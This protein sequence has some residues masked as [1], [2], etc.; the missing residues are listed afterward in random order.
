MEATLT[1]KKEA[2]NTRRINRMPLNLP[3][4]AEGRDTADSQWEEITRLRDVSSF[5]AAFTLSRPVK[6]GRLI[7]L[8]LPMP[9]Q[10]RCYD[11]FEAQYHVWGVV[12]RCVAEENAEDE[13]YVLGVAFIGKVPPKSFLEDPSRLFDVSHKSEDEHGLWEVKPLESEQEET[14][15][16]SED[17]RHSRYDIPVNLTV[18]LLDA[19]GKVT[20]T[21][22]TVTENISLSGASIFTSL[23]VENGR[24]LKVTSVQDGAVIKAIVRGKRIGQDGIPRLH[25]EFI[26]QMFPLSGIID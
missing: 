15:L 14:Q 4:K 18:E 3:L 21:E 13:T 11:F 10:M 20:E 19:D 9:R 25:I 22:D 17:R 7:K 1:E 12:R 5:G 2:A 8:V 26:D 24:F 6:R 16:P 23:T